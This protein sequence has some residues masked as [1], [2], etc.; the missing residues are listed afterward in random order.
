MKDSERADEPL[1]YSEKLLGRQVHRTN[2]E[3]S[4]SPEKERRPAQICGG[5]AWP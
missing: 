3:E 5:R 1:D 2:R 4:G